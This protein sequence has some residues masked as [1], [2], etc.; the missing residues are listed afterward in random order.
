MVT[1]VVVNLLFLKYAHELLDVTNHLFLC[2]WWCW[3]RV[4]SP[5]S[6]S[7]LARLSVSPVSPVSRSS[8]APMPLLRLTG[9]EWKLL[10]PSEVN[11]FPSKPFLL[12]C[13]VG[14]NSRSLL[15]MVSISLLKIF[16]C[17]LDSS[18]S[19]CFPEGFISKSCACVHNEGNNFFLR[20]PYVLIIIIARIQKDID[21]NVPATM[22]GTNM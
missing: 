14:L 13:F 2:P 9:L 21:N 17:A 15:N 20:Y 6:V 3:G 11:R 22:A 4:S 7:P 10:E 18:A 16:S 5:G 8:L 19:L 12:W 1:S